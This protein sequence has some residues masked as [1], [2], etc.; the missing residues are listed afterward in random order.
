M[1]SRIIA[2]LKKE[3]IHIVRDPRSLVIVFLLPL[4]MVLLYGYAITFDIREIGLGLLDQDRTPASREMTERLLGSGYF[5]LGGRLES[6]DEIEPALMHRRFRAVLIIPKGYGVSLATQLRTPVQVIVDGSNANSATVAI[7]YLKSFFTTYSLELN[8]LVVQPPIELEPRVW[9]N[10]DLK[11]AHFIV[12]GLVAVVMMLICA[13]LTS[14][15]VAR[16]RETG[17]M[18]QILVSP[19][20]SIEIIVGKTLPY[21]LLALVDAIFVVVFS[22]QWFGVPF[23]GNALW[24]LAYAMIYVYA[25]LSMG[26]FISARVRSQQVALM[27]AQVATLLPS[28][29]LSGFVFPLI[30]MP[31]ILQAISFIVPAKYFLIIIR[32]IMLKGVDGLMLW[33]PAL[34]LVS[35]GTLLILV[36]VKRFK[37]NLE[38]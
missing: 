4:M 7:N 11:S 27:A 29:L 21:I 38:V 36:S 16:E 9:Y 6:R 1:K 30:A 20:R 15:T 19:I 10:P 35:F 18:E 31:T 17:T 33:K 32:G 5:K 12:P 26:I 8:A 3:F 22:W 28:I 37:T 34:F 25:S 24:L 13:L 14:V 2:I 23:R